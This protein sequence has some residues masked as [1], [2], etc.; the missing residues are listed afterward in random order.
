VK[1]TLTRL[2]FATNKID[3]DARNLQCCKE[4]WMQ[5]RQTPSRTIGFGLF[6][7]LFASA[8]LALAK[9]AVKD[10][11]LLA[12]ATSEQP[13]VIKTLEKLVN[14]E[15]GTGDA[16]GMPEMAALLEAELKSLGAAVTRH[17]SEGDVV[18]D[19]IVGRIAGTG[20]KKILMIAHMD[21]VYERGKL[22]SAPFRIDGNKAYGPGIAD[23]KS[24]IAVILHSLRL[25]QQR[26]FKDF[27]VITVS[28]NTDEE[29]GSRGSRELIKTLANEHDV[30][31]SF[32]PTIDK[33]PLLGGEVLVLGASGI[34][35]VDVTIKGLS[36]HAG[37]MPEAGVN[38]IVE[39]SDLVLRTIDLDKGQG[40]LRFNWTMSTGGNTPNVV[41][42]HATLYAD[43]R[44]PTN[45]SFDE[46]QKEL[47]ARI[48]KP[49]IPGAEVVVKIDPGRPAFVANDG[50]KRLVDRAVEIYKLLGS[51]IK[52][53][54]FTG[55]GTDAAY[56][57]LSG[58]PVIETLGLPG[59][60][61]HSNLAEYVLIDAIPRR[62]YLT[63]QLIMDISQSK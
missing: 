13:A 56:A 44:Y 23:D 33:H 46:M 40:G 53:I 59:F 42:D 48:A 12:A 57:A 58:H 20:S 39:A 19:N 52:I 30:I 29:R 15:T 38:A 45:E 26:G 2:R 41:P 54:P 61:Y 10:D 3:F 34:G 36:A 31:L 49:R 43:V 35:A 1:R 25:L 4:Q 18:G 22:A 16:V 14:I 63:V 6:L 47:K 5:M 21:T 55:G 32:E 28:F 60:G 24:G 50:G 17:K 9:D 8:P 11:A 37:A 7:T 51:D 27:G 62:L